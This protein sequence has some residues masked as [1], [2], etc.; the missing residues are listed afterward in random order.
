MTMQAFVS[1]LGSMWT[2]TT[3][4]RMVVL[5]ATRRSVRWMQ[6]DQR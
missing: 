3:R 2:T 5:K 6:P 1:R 4:N